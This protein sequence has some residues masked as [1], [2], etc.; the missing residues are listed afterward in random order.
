[1]RPHRATHQFSPSP[2]RA[3]LH[4][5]LFAQSW[6]SLSDYSLENVH[7]E[8]WGCSPCWNSGE[9]RNSSHLIPR[10]PEIAKTHLGK[11]SCEHAGVR[12]R[13]PGNFPPAAG[14]PPVCNL[15]YF[16][17]FLSKHGPERGS[18]GSF[19]EDYHQTREHFPESFHP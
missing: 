10:H 8:I 19:P 1:M 4:T 9:P 17:T 16:H 6:P 14:Q 11:S 3:P 18:A 2:S 5:P 15:M 12:G 13:F 7:I